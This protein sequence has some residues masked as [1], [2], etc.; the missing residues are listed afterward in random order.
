MRCACSAC[1]RARR[2]RAGRCRLR[3]SA[4][5][6]AHACR[7][8]ARRCSS[9]PRASAG[10]RS[11]EKDGWVLARDARLASGR[12]HLPGVRLRRRNLA[13]SS[14]ADLDAHRCS[15]YST[16]R[17]KD[18]THSARRA[19]DR[20]ARRA[21]AEGGAR[22]G[23]EARRRG[24]LLQD[25]PGALHRRG[26]LR[27][28]RLAHRA[29]Q[30]GVRRPQALRHPGDRAPRGRQPARP[31]RHL[32]HRARPPLGDGGGGAREGRDEDPRGHGADQ[33]RPARPR[34]DGLDAGPSS[35]WCSRGRAA[36]PR[37]AATA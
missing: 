12:R 22:A 23:R 2:T 20:R 18:M 19:P 6:A 16:R 35:S 17:R 1:W 9:A 26:L 34:R 24:A 10:R 36:R 11:T 13:A 31:R 29:R 28:A 33:L 5:E 21:D 30:Q 32:P 37:A 4:R 14:D 27:A 15:E 3:R 25:R 8:A 7:T